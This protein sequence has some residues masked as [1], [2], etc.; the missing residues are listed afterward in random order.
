M[1]NS[2]NKKLAGYYLDNNKDYTWK[3][4]LQAIVKEGF[5]LRSEEQKDTYC[6]YFYSAQYGMFWPG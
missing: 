3:A 5:L 2:K 1:S 6:H 4:Y